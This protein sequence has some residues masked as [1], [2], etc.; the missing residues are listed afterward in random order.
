MYSLWGGSVIALRQIVR[1]RP[2]RRGSL[3]AAVLQPTRDRIYTAI[4]VGESRPHWCAVVVTFEHAAESV[5]LCV[6]VCVCGVCVC[7]CACVRARVCVLVCMRVCVCVCA[8]MCV[9]ICGV[10]ACVRMW[11]EYIEILCSYLV[12]SHVWEAVKGFG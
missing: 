6:Y 10:C 3:V 12:H 11:R 4:G 7:V 9:Y 5:K 8:C 1:T 2:F